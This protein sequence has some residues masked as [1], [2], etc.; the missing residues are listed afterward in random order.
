[1]ALCVDV[2][3]LADLK[4]EYR[5]ATVDLKVFKRISNALVMRSG[6]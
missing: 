4:N 6:P 5:A 3:R 2:G 1:M